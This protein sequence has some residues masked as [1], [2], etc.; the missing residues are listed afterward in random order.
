MAGTT[1][2]VLAVALTTV[3]VLASVP[4]PVSAHGNS[5]SVDSQVA[6][7]GTIVVEN[8]LFVSDGFIV[9]HAT[10][11]TGGVG[12]ALGERF[13]PNGLGLQ[14]GVTVNVSD[15]A[16][17]EW[18][19]EREVWVVAHHDT[20]RNGEFDPG[21]DRALS[22][23]G[24]LAG[25][26][27][28]VGKSDAPANV[29]VE[30]FSRVEAANGTMTLHGVT[31]PEP[32]YVALERASENGSVELVGVT[33]LDAGTH[34]DVAVNLTES[35]LART[36]GDVELRAKLYREGSEP[37]AIRDRPSARANDPFTAGEE[38]VSTLFPATVAGDGATSS[39]EVQVNTPRPTTDVPASG[40]STDRDTAT[41][42]GATAD[43]ATDPR[44]DGTS[45][46]TGPGFGLAVAALAVVGALLALA[47]R[48][49][50]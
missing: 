19:D 36:P 38:N 30:G 47:R 15:D 18:G 9:V 6:A 44:S 11:E 37:F 1:R 17:A 50:P 3:L 34:R 23:F 20:N 14:R 43:D 40:A 21:T 13:V 39:S 42:G 4:L 29:V 5:V 28:T 12:P 10:N 2:R 8:S 27:V 46:G 49:R 7:D 33:R 22:S 32:G 25:E 35:F 48:P 41:A 26:R 16:W 31:L 24:R 45:S